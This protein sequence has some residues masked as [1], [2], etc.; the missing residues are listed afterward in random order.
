MDRN[1]MLDYHKALENFRSAAKKLDV[2]PWS[3]RWDALKIKPW[4]LQ[5]YITLQIYD[6]KLES[7]EVGMKAMECTICSKTLTFDEKYIRVNYSQVS[8]TFHEAFHEGCL[9]ACL[10]GQDR[11]NVGVD[12]VRVLHGLIHRLNADELRTYRVEIEKEAQELL[13]RSGFNLA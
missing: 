13:E 5:I 10:L 3:Y 8:H 7:G 6:I 9:Q 1:A 12:C 2:M 11:P 4:I